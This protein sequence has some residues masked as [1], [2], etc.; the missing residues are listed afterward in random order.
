MTS[1]QRLTLAEQIKERFPQW[2]ITTHAFR[3]DETVIL[4]RE[5]LLEVC[6]YLR[7]DPAMAFN[8]LMDLT[9]VDLLTMGQAEL[10]E[11]FRPIPAVDPSLTWTSFSEEPQGPRNIFG[12]PSPR[13]E[14]VYHLF[15]LVHKHRLRLKVP[16]EESDP[17]VN[18][19]TSIWK[20]ANWFE[21]EVW[22]M[23]GIV[24][25]DHPNLKRILMYDGFQGHPLRKDYPV[26]KRQ[27]L[28]GPVN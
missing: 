24:F 2:I 23:F 21:R 20:G 11:V 22:D 18:S 17:V 1:D 4:K 27:L 7:D 9:A 8:F 14:V 5:G 12:E 10:G 13:F 15:S 26:N 19:V 28:I 6:R 16:V 25:R 3:G